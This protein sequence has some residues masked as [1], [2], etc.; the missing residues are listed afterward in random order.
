MSTPTIRLTPTKPFRRR[1]RRSVR[2]S[3]WVAG[4]I[5]RPSKLRVS[6]RGS[7]Y[8]TTI[9]TCPRGICVAGG[10]RPAE[11]STVAWVARRSVPMGPDSCRSAAGDD[12]CCAG[13]T[14]GGL[15]GSQQLLRRPVSALSYN[16]LSAWRS[17][18]FVPALHRLTVRQI[19]NRYQLE[20]EP[21]T[22]AD[23]RRRGLSI[24]RIAVQLGRV[25]ST[26]SREWTKPPLPASLDGWS[27]S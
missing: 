9:S 1:L 10:G 21:I 13:V 19:S 7:S 14:S 16:N 18:Q 20:E 8:R 26:I 22:I 2:L 25:P 24:R 27:T 4:Q 15:H 3:T 12:G 17:R 23:L 11:H 5:S 6:Q